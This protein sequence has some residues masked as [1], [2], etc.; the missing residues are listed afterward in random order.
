[1]LV[2]RIARAAGP[3]VRVLVNERA[4]VAAAL[5]V[6]VHLRASSLPAA[7][8]AP[9]AAGGGRGSRRPCTTSPTSPPPPAPMR[10]SPAPCGRRRR[11][12]RR[13]PRS[14]CLAS[15]RIA[16]ATPVPVVGIGGTHR[17]HDSAGAAVEPAGAAG[18]AAIGAFLPRP[19]ETVG[20]AVRRAM[21]VVVDSPGTAA[22][23][24]SRRGARS[25]SDSHGAR[26]GRR[27]RRG[28]APPPRSG[29]PM[30]ARRGR[31]DQAGRAHARGARA[32]PRRRSSRQASSAA[33]S[34]GR[35]AGDGD[36]ARP[37]NHAAGVPRPSSRRAAA[38][39]GRPS[40]RSPTPRCGRRA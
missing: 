9:L 38:A 33:P 32:Q 2:E 25:G 22:L 35:Y 10:S 40:V 1:M 14:A 20:D 5:G 36:R 18:L 11:S 8:A 13:R 23:L 27:F 34:C 24:I 37:G 28:A 3:R 39:R 4:D 30:A 21:T 7:R 16:A 19:G 29:A 26:H 12:R 15:A 17:R 31:R 6:G